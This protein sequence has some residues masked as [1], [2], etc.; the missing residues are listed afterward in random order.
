MN[1]GT[2]PLICRRIKA[3]RE[4]HGFTQEEIARA[5]PS[6]YNRAKPMSLGAYRN[7]EDHV[8]PKE[9]QLR[10]LARFY[11]GQG[12]DISEDYFIQPDGQLDPDQA[13]RLNRRLLA[14]EAAAEEMRESL[15]E[16][17]ALVESLLAR[18]GTGQGGGRPAR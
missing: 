5:I 14:Q 11:I 17:R 18:P 16:V 6:A 15:E 13:D 1:S 9:W 3:F 4:R 8:E 12:V 2:Q 7:W 10:R